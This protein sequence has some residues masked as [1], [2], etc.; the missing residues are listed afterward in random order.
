MEK[1]I[2]PQLQSSISKSAEG[3][4]EDLSKLTDEELLKWSK[5]ELVRRL[6][7]SETEKMS[8]IVDHSNLIREVNR[9][10]QQH[11]NEIRG[12]KEV[13]QKLQEDNQELRDLCCFLDDDRQKGKKVSREW[14][15]L[16]RYSAGIM[17]KEVTLYLQKLKE[18]EQRQEE[19]VR[20]NLELRELCLMLD[21]EKGSG[22]TGRSAGTGG[23]AGCRN[24]IDSQ[25]SLSHASGPGPGLLRDVGDGSSTS[26]AGSTDSPDHLTHKQQLLGGPVGGSPDHLHKPGSGEEAPG[27]EHTSRR[28]STSQEYAAHTYPQ[29]CRSR[30]GSFS[31]PDHKGLRG[32]SPEKLGKSLS[33][34]SPEQ[35]SKHL[36]VSSQPPGSPDLFQKH[37]ASM[38]SMCGSP[39]PKQILSGTPEHLQKGRVISGSPELSRHQHSKFGSPGREVAQKRPGV[40]E[41]SPHHRSIYSALISAGCCS[42]SCRSVRLWDSFDA[43]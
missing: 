16:G 19:V 20:E 43:S 6:R 35:F 31:S 18:L 17:R 14:Q 29:V 27:P 21:E 11:L 22:V 1:P 32:F 25:S 33:R 36:L 23:P 34:G 12:L 26:S 40:E 7:R 38:G 5:E 13:N 2:Q 37:R 28:H 15:R 30:C 42:S 39:E 3:P 4:S 8:V 10:L 9:R 41:M 24:S